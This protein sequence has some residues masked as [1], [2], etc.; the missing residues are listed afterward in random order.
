MILNQTSHKIS[1]LKSDR[2]GEF[3][4]NEFNQ[5][6][7][8]NGIIREMGPAESPEQNSVV[9]RFMRTIASCLLSQ[10]IHGNLPIKLWGEVIIATSF[11]L[12]LCPSKSLQYSCPEFAWQHLALGINQP[13][14]PYKR[15]KVLG[16]LAY[17]IPPGHRNKLAPRLVRAIMIGYERNLNA[18]RLWDPATNRVIVS[19]DVVFNEEVFP[20]REHDK[21]NT[22]ELTILNDETWHDAWE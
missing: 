14:L 22:E 21:A 5:F 4:S 2:G 7:S 13:S 20:L 11:I 16:C 8:V 19:N 15:L 6:L 12:N 10:L 1:V 9:E 17:S 3:N 18:Y